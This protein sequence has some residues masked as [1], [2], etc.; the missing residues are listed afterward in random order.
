M[1]GGALFDFHLDG[2][3]NVLVGCGLG[4]TSL[5]NANVAAVPDDR[6]FVGNDRWP[7]AL[8]TKNALTDHYKAAR[9]MLNPQRIATLPRK[10]RMLA[11]ATGS[12]GATDIRA[13]INVTFQP[14]TST[15]GVHQDGCTGCGDCVTGCNVGAKNTVLMNYL[16]KAHHDGAQI[17]TEVEVRTVRRRGDRWLVAYR[18]RGGQANAFAGPTRIVTAD[19]VVLSAGTLGTTEILLR[20][21]AAGLE[22]SDQLGHH[23]SGNGDV[24]AFGYDETRRVN[25]IGVAQQPSRVD[26]PPGP[27]ISGMVTYDD[28]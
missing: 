12:G 7:T 21:A 4:G 8:R 16:P 11:A 28:G 17:F 27:C 9:K 10:T 13:F 25:G 3:M 5:I 1:I 19:A 20:S 24:L 6:V 26:E 18:P 23:F 2:D 15:G 22:L 14:G